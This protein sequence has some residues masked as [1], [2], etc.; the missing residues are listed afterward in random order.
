MS[1]NLL[2]GLLWAS[3]VLVFILIWFICGMIYLIDKNPIEYS[4]GA[5]KL[6]TVKEYLILGPM[7]FFIDFL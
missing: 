7:A 5:D 4:E 3:G 2:S 1:A 6:N